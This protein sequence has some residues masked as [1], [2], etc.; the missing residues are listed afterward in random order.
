MTSCALLWLMVHH[1]WSVAFFYNFDFIFLFTNALYILQ[2]FLFWRLES[3]RDFLHLF[4]ETAKSYLRM[5][6]TLQLKKVYII[7]I[8]NVLIYKK[9]NY[10]I[11]AL[12]LQLVHFFYFVNIIYV[13]FF[14][15]ISWYLFWFGYI[16]N[17]SRLYS[18]DVLYRMFSHW[19]V[20]KNSWVLSNN[21]K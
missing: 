14:L 4:V 9:N 1:D 18:M 11:T 20:L 10:L 15:Y 2:L 13:Y 3:K 17:V 5:W 16:A 19:R 6:G 21:L 7:L 12:G 8:I